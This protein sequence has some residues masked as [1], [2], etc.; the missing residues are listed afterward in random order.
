MQ[1][2]KSVIDPENVK[3]CAKFR[4]ELRNYDRRVAEN[5]EKIFYMYQKYQNNH[6]YNKQF[7]CEAAKEQEIP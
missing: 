5:L 2:L 4:W 3:L 1:A 7:C 6:I